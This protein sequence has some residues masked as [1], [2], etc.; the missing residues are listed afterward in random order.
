MYRSGR[1][2]RA[3]QTRQQLVSPRSQLAQLRYVPRAL[4]LVW[5]AAPGWT[6]ASLA[7]VIAQGVLP[8]FTVY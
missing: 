4:R 6:V 1:F 5:D 3:D 8:V 2:H 7:L